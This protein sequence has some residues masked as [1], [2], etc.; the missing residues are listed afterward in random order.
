MQELWIRDD[1]EFVWESIM[2]LKLCFDMM[3]GIGRYST[4]RSW[5]SGRI[6]RGN[7]YR[8]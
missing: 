3:L 2:A 7:R 4:V 1:N 8:S 6:Y 5:I